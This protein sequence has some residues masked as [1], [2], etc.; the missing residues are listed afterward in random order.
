MRFLLYTLTAALTV[1]PAFAQKYEISL[2]GGG[3]FYQSHT[4]TNPKGD[5]DAG[6]ATG[7]AGSVA[8]G[9]NMYRHVGGEIRYTYLHNDAKLKSGSTTANFGAEAHLINYDF[10]IHATSTEATVRPYV[11]VGGG[12]KLYRGTG[13][14]V[15]FQPLSNIA[16]LTKTSDVQG[17]LSVGTG[18]KVALTSRM[19]FRVDVH[20]YITPFPRKVIT[21]ALNSKASGWFNNIVATAGISFAF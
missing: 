6:F 20:D 12:M 21:P 10:L 4:V 8:V 17:M 19:S 11:A 9:N 16:L 3:S 2:A 18:V 15:P 13:T 5:A 14:E 7:W 1:L